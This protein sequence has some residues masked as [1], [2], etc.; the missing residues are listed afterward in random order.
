MTATHTPHSPYGPL[1]RYADK[2][3]FDVTPEPQAKR[4]RPGRHLSF[5]IQKHWAS[6]LHYDFRL[7]HEGVLLSWAIPKGPSCDPKVK[8]MA[9]QVE[10]HP[11]SY[12]S[13]EGTIPPRQY[14][15]GEVIV[16]DRGTWEPV[17]SAAEGLKQGK[18]VFKLHGEKLAGLWELVR[19]SKPGDKR[20]NWLLFKK[21][22]EWAR[23]S[24]EYDVTVALPDS[25]I[26][27]PLGAPQPKTA[28]LPKTLKPQLA[29]LAS[30]LPTA[31]D[32][33]YEF[34]F[35]GYRILARLEHGRARLF[36]R[37]GQD[38]TDKMPALVRDVESLGIQCAWLDGEVVALGPDGL[39]HFNT[40]QNAFDEG[41][42]APLVWYVFDSPYFEG[43][44]LRDVPLVQRRA[45]LQN[46][47]AKKATATIRFSETLQG[48]ATALWRSACAA[49]L[50][51]LMA[52]RADAPYVNARSDTW[53]KIKCTQ[54]QEFIILGYTERSTGA[55]D[56]GSL[57][58][59]Y[60]GESGELQC[61]GHVGTGWDERARKDLYQRMVAIE[62]TSPPEGLTL[63]GRGRWASRGAGIV[64]WVR[65]KLVA[66]VRFGEWTPEGAIRHASFQGLRA[67][68]PA[69]QIVRERATSGKQVDTR[70]GKLRI[71]HADR[72]IDTSTG[73]TKL[74][75]VRYYESMAERILPHLKGRPV[76]LLRAPEGLGGDMFFQKHADRRLVPG[77][78]AFI[79]VSSE[80]ALIQAVQMN[81]MEFHT[82]NA[83]VHK[84]D[85]PDRLIFDLDPGEGV[86]WPHVR[87]AATLVH[88]LLDELGL[89]NWL[90]TSGGKGLH[91]VVPIAS[92]LDW[93]SVK[94]FSHAVVAH[95][96]RTI[97]SRFVAKSGPKNR[98]GRIFVDYLRNGEGQ[99]TVAA[100]SARA[101]PGLGVSMPLA[102]DQL[103]EL[104]R[105]AQWTIATAR[106]YLSFARDD[107]WADYW[108]CK[109]TLTGAVRR[110]AGLAEGH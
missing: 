42:T 110:M 33:V 28:A 37:N 98:V 108:A 97:P 64:H 67:D 48:P 2:R 73:L 61:A 30:R 26:Q 13:F 43:R 70:I 101:R 22:D 9:V 55:H 11:L 81:V 27:H 85:R 90:K 47:L 1:Q 83:K 20:D 16:W 5:V 107:P 25:V 40:L 36:T 12:G 62:T 23:P 45:L 24:D 99:T 50:E 69:R 72:V 77:D 76:A 89:R 21:H 44:D 88:A 35:D 94:D 41:R 56:F 102:W 104:Q 4:A 87:E 6:H 52:K 57:V 10:D 39:P 105:S 86:E 59:G 18:L 19:I 63:R 65:P 29:T 80:T 53:L 66:E 68:K 103:N 38:W 8:R 106:D 93:A 3:N 7:E 79:E 54:R 109:Q 92:R 15:A 32:W 84:L 31:G 91:V 71:T 95:L 96:A 49:Q 51:G 58:L 75:L 14:G 74:D 17:G 46:L 78:S 82:W 100:F 34:K 60:H